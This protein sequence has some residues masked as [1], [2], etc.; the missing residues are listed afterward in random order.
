M[1]PVSYSRPY[2]ELRTHKWQYLLVFFDVPPRPAATNNKRALEF[3]WANCG[4]RRRPVLGYNLVEA[5][6]KRWMSSP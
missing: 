2:L 3:R 6:L 1:H 4:P 5:C